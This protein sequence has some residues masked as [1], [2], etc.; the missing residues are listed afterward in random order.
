MKKFLSFHERYKPLYF[1]LV[2]LLT[3]GLLLTFC[4]FFWASAFWE[5]VSLSYGYPETFTYAE[6]Q[7]MCTNFGV[8]CSF[9]T[10]F[11]LFVVYLFDGIKFCR[12]TDP[13]QPC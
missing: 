9:T 2:Q 6:C 11:V 10:V 13:A 4:F 12:K 8:C 1:P 7:T 5:F 3:L